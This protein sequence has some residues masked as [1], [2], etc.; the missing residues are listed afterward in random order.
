[1]CLTSLWSE[2][3]AD[4]PDAAVPFASSKSPVV[5][6]ATAKQIEWGTVHGSAAAPPTSPASSAVAAETLS[7]IPYGA[8]HGL[9]M[10]ELPTL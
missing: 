6:K 8:T 4:A 5:I 7:M 1:M 2:Q 10:V 9:S 3:V